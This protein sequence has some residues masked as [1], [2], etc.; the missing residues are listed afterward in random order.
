MCIID[1]YSA[2]SFHPTFAAECVKYFRCTEVK[3]AR[4]GVV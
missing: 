2:F 1:A 4:D 3:V